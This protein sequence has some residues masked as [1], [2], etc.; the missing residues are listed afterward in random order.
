MLSV[1]LF[2]LFFSKPQDPKD[3]EDVL[4]EQ[5]DQ[6]SIVGFSQP[7][8][9]L[10]TSAVFVLWRLLTFHGHTDNYSASSASTQNISYL[11]C[12]WFY[13]WGVQLFTSGPVCPRANNR[14][15]H[16]SP[17]FTYNPRRPGWR[18]AG[19]VTRATAPAGLSEQSLWTHTGINMLSQPSDWYQRVSQWVSEGNRGMWMRMKPQ[20]KSTDP[21]SRLY[22]TVP[23]TFNAVS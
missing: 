13:H 4:E 17:K 8:S 9:V 10:K 5:S 2:C 18:H 14:H 7:P 11:V 21:H 20:R 23:K 22:C 19:N 12:P 6:M 16:D 15:T 3:P 1:H